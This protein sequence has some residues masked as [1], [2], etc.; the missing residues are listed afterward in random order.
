MNIFFSR[1][2]DLITALTYLLVDNFLCPLIAPGSV[3]LPIFYQQTFLNYNPP[4]S[5]DNYFKSFIKKKQFSIYYRK[6]YYNV[7]QGCIQVKRSLKG[8]VGL[9]NDFS[10]LSN[11]SFSN[12]AIAILDFTLLLPI[13]LSLFQLLRQRRGKVILLLFLALKGDSDMCFLTLRL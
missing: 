2:S 4:S 8:L 6:D 7:S 11:S 5:F 10:P 13:Q 9:Y 12:I 1:P 3:K